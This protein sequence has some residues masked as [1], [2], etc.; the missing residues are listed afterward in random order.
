MV[1][2]TF[3]SFCLVPYARIDCFQSLFKVIVEK[4]IKKAQDTLRFWNSSQSIEIA[5]W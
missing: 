2:M 5:A 4:P 1:N 3:S